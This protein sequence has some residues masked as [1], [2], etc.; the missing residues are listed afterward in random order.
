MRVSEGHA[1]SW[2]G[3]AAGT[4]AA[5][6]QGGGL[7]LASAPD[8]VRHAALRAE[9]HSEPS[10]GPRSAR[11][12]GFT[13]GGLRAPPRGH[14]R[15]CRLPGPPPPAP[16]PRFRFRGRYRAAQPRPPP[17]FSVAPGSR[18]YVSTNPTALDRD[19]HGA[20]GDPRAALALAAH[21]ASHARAAGTGVHGPALPG[22]HFSALVRARLGRS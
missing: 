2:P 14:S 12:P 7:V 22:G 13:E 19:T 9:P 5:R 21:S 4:A 18:C 17:A 8:A 1:G 3:Q 16:G 11:A 20:T 15:N 6:I 10:R